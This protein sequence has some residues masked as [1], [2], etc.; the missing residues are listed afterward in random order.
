MPLPRNLSGESVENV[1][2]AIE[3]DDSRC[4]CG[5]CQRYPQAR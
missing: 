4:R 2:I 1:D 3:N 5:L